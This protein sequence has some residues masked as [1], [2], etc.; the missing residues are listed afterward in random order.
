MLPEERRRRILDL[1]EANGNLQAKEL[2][3]LLNTSE[4]TIRRDL[5]RLEEGGELTRVHGGALPRSRVPLNH[6]ARAS[7][8]LDSKIAIAKKA[9][10]L[11][12][13]A[14]VIALDGGTTALEIARY[15]SPDYHGT[16]VTNNLPAA[17][18]LAE[19]PNAEVVVIG[20]KLFKP[21]LDTVGASL[22]RFVSE[23]RFDLCFVGAASV[24]TKHGF[25]SIDYEEVQA[26]RAL[27][28]S[29]DR[30]F[31]VASSEKLGTS[32]PFIFSKL[33]EITDLITDSNAGDDILESLRQ[34]DVQIHKA[35]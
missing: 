4:D 7:R 20:G 17:I 3:K 6:S 34:A 23:M 10:S 9:A 22:S 35:P 19:H 25:G 18:L 8:T 15:L 16:I 32:S 29:S 11:I 14:G 2:T 30:T 26:K 33:N 21:A 31:C 1:L 28:M 27:V 12:G 13:S 5:R 24:D